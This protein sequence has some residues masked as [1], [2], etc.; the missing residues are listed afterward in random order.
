[1]TSLVSMLH[2][3]WADICEKEWLDQNMKNFGG[4]VRYYNNFDVIGVVVTV[5]DSTYLGKS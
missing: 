2:G 1:M 3:A 4:L 5:K